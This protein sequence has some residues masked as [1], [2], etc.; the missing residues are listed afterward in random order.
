MAS[1]ND[2]N[3]GVGSTALSLFMPGFTLA[4]FL[5]AFA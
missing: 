2:N 5:A 4:A 3:E 1:P